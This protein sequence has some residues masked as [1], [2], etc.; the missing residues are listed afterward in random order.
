[1][2]ACWEEVEREGEGKGTGK[3]EEDRE[4]RGR[5]IGNK[6]TWINEREREDKIGGEKV[7]KE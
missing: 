1:M 6:R 7:V 2:S 3:G 5:W 4:E